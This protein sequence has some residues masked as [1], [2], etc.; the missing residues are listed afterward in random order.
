MV[1]LFENSETYYIVLEYMKGKDLF[2]YIKRR[3]YSLREHRVQD[4]I[5]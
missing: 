4:L 5:Y 3:D 2:E 1:D